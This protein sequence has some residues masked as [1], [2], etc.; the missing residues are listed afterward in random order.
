MS[1]LVTQH[2][3]IQRCYYGH[4]T[5]PSLVTQQNCWQNPPN[6]VKSDVILLLFWENLRPNNLLVSVKTTTIQGIK[7]TTKP[8]FSSKD[9]IIVF[10][11]WI[12]FSIYPASVY[13]LT[14]NLV[15]HQNYQET[16]FKELKMPARYQSP[17]YLLLGLGIWLQFCIILWKAF[18][19]PATVKSL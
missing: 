7:V 13:A 2:C 1:L 16:F 10:P 12:S 9:I 19:I 5:A 14:S 11:W 3:V 4:T 8:L 15:G 17:A 18:T 6:Q